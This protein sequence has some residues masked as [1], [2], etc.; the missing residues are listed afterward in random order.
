MGSS[1]SALNGISANEF[2]RKYVGSESIPPADPLWREFLYI[3]WLPAE[4]NEMN[5]L[6]EMNPS[7]LREFRKHNIKTHNLSALMKFVVSQGTEFLGSDFRSGGNYD[8]N[9]LTVVQNSLLVFRISA[10]YLLEHTTEQNFLKHLADESVEVFGSSSLLECFFQVL[11]SLLLKV[12]VNSETYALHCEILTA[13]LILLARQMHRDLSSPLPLVFVYVM[14][15]KCA[16]LAPA[17]VQR[18]LTNFAENV[19][20]PAGFQGQPA[21]SSFLWRAASSLAGGLLTV[22]TLGYANRGQATTTTSTTATSAPT[23]SVKTKTIGSDHSSTEVPLTNLV[24]SE[25]PNPGT[26]IKTCHPLADLSSLLLLV[27]TTQAGSIL[28]CSALLAE[29]GLNAQTAT[30]NP[31]R[32]ALFSITD[33]NAPVPDEKQQDQ[34]V[35]QTSASLKGV[36]SVTPPEMMGYSVDFLSIRDTAADTLHQ[37]NSTL[38]LYLLLHRN[39]H[40]RNFL[41]QRRNY[42]KLLLPLLNI[43]Y[44][45][46]GDSSPL[47]YM[48]LIIVL[49]LTESEQFNEE[50]HS[51]PINWVTWSANRRISSVSRGSLLI[52]IL[53]RTIR[54]HL[55]RLKDRYLHVNILAALANLSAKVTNMHSFVSDSFMCVLQLLAKRYNRTVEQLRLLSSKETQSVDDKSIANTDK[56]TG[57]AVTQEEDSMVQELSLLEE[58]IRMVL[59]ILNSI[60]THVLAE[61]V[62][63]TYSLLYKRDCLNSLRSHPAFQSVIQNLDTIISYFTKKM[64]QE[65]G[66][67]PTSPS[68]LLELI[69]KHSPHINRHCNL[70]KFPD[71][72]FKYVEEESP[73]EFFIPYVWTIVLHQSGIAFQTEGLSLF[74]TEIPS[75][76][77]RNHVDEDAGDRQEEV[78][79]ELQ[80]H[81]HSSCTDDQP[82]EI[83]EMTTFTDSTPTAV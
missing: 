30:L 42:D 48:A 62:N 41:L 49:I 18:L 21:P 34:E 53:L 77:T 19:D 67:T 5:R 16:S 58:V 22:V 70:K 6:E 66:E 38:L 78:Q 8:R 83:S 72:K 68:A 74:S 23:T 37:D 40:F 7:V 54:Y 71:L 82:H 10:K 31:Y 51:V 46:P 55:N 47:V 69:R 45:S 13:I 27:L 17:V 9:L 35:P 36:V 56:Q 73:D 52:L 2:L 32:V 28:K 3:Q 39:A 14:W 65:L 61:N 11:F 12:P 59:E 20:P 4:Y 43:I 60:L 1:S 26:N 64:E 81:K 79:R 25:C 33:V 57:S 44:R 75:D 50:I 76:E 80:G 24:T 29:L 63:L 15:G